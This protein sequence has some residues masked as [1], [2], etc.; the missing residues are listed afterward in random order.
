MKISLLRVIP[1]FAIYLFDVLFYEVLKAGEVV[2]TEMIGMIE[3][4]IFFF[5][6]LV[7]GICNSLVFFYLL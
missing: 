1:A 5:V 4:L 3:Q 7:E 2:D 6:V